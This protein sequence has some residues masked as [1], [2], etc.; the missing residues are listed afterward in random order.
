[1]QTVLAFDRPFQGARVQLFS[2]RRGWTDVVLRALTGSDTQSRGHIF[3]GK[4]LT[5]VDAAAQADF[6]LDPLLASGTTVLMYGGFLH[7]A[8]VMA[9]LAAGVDG[10]ISELA[11]RS[12]LLHAMSQVLEG[13]Q[14][15]PFRLPESV[16]AARA[17]GVVLTSTERRAAIAYFVDMPSSSRAVVAAGLGM[18]DKTLSTHLHSIRRKIKAQP[19]E[20]RAAVSRRISAAG[21]LAPETPPVRPGMPGRS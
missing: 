13:T 11:H 10:Y 20:S 7:S 14:V 9:L 4:T 17:Y 5:L 6:P 15:A 1:M 12:E 18:S 19:G 3:K 16:M 2:R 21:M 8:R